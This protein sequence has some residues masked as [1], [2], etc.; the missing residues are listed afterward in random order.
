M[1]G[2]VAMKDGPGVGEST[3][4]LSQTGSKK[5][6]STAANAGTERKRPPILP[7]AKSMPIPPALTPRTQYAKKV[8]LACIVLGESVRA[9]LGRVRSLVMTNPYI[10]VVCSVHRHVNC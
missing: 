6:S 3:A 2:V 5:D 8:R 1:P 4:L 10:R 7:S 9:Y